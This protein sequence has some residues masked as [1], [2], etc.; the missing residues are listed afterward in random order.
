MNSNEIENNLTLRVKSTNNLDNN[1]AIMF[2]NTG[3]SSTI[4]LCR[5]YVSGV[6]SNRA[7]FVI[8]TVYMRDHSSKWTSLTEKLK[9]PSWTRAGDILVEN[10]D[11]ENYG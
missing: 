1:N 8:R 3:D 11:L 5:S 6:V 9:S 10:Q 4:A 2:K 7:N